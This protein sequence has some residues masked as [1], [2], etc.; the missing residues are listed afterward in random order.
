[1]TVIAWDGKTLAGDKLACGGTRTTVTK[2]ARLPD[3]RLIGL[4]GSGSIARELAAWALAGEDPSNW[5]ESADKDE[6]S[7][8]V[9]TRG[10]LPRVY[11]NR[12]F[13][14]LPE[15]KFFAMGCGEAYA[16]AAMYLGHDA[17]RG[18][19]IACALDANCGSGIDTLTL[20]DA[21]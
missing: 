14:M 3:G 6:A 12:P 4:A 5:P 2:I 17:R 1:M 15:D 10:Q 21:P 11:Y 16:M 18:V 13:P 8:I 20:E 7:M 19:E 9:I